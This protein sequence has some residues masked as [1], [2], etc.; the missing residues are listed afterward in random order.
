MA[1]PNIVLCNFESIL[2]FSDRIFQARI[3]KSSRGSIFLNEVV[4]LPIRQRN[5]IS[6]NRCISNKKSVYCAGDNSACNRKRIICLVGVIGIVFQLL[7]DTGQLRVQAINAWCFDFCISR[8]NILCQLLI[9]LFC[10]VWQSECTV[11]N[12]CVLR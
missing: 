10:L 5:I 7:I 6:C 2:E 1:L 11:N 9:D 8:Y 3:I 4:Y 12:S